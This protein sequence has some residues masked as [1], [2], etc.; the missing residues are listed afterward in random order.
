[1][2][3]LIDTSFIVTVF[4]NNVD[5]KHEFTKFGNVKMVVLDLVIKETERLAE[6][7]G[8]DGMHARLALEFMKQ[9]N[10]R[11]YRTKTE[12][13]DKQLERIA[14]KHGMA[15]CTMDKKLKEYLIRKGIP[16]ITI[17]QR[18]YLALARKHGVEF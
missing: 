14:R 4:A 8:K 11:I 6:G 10:A 3:V 12:H 1:M 7:R 18:R 16:V 17:R 5:I 9:G 15:V 13:T 2:E